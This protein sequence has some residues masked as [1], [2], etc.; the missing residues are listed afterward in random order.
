ME[1]VDRIVNGI[2]NGIGLSLKRYPNRE[3]RRLL[4]YLAEHSIHYLIDVGA[5][6]GQ[7]GSSMLQA[8]FKGEIL[9][10]EPQAEAFT[11]L[12]KRAE[13]TKNWK[14][15]H[16]AMGDFDGQSELNIAGNSVSSSLLSMLPAHLN[17]APKSVYVSRESIEVKKLETIYEGLMK[18]EYAFL[19]MDT[20]GFEMKVLKGAERILDKIVGIQLEMACHPLYDGEVLFDEMKAYLEGKDYFLSS[21]ENGFYDKETGRLLQVDAVFLRELSQ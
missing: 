8:G 16:F 10:F 13:S 21:L 18:E 17:A 6:E 14:T 4:Q 9:S 12:R 19:K 15:F 2:L 20:Q 5:N 7:F 11:K 3:Q 1:K